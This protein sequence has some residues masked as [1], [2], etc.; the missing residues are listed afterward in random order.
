MLQSGAA[1]AQVLLSQLSTLNLGAISREIRGLSW[2]G[3]GGGGA[4]FQGLWQ[5]APVAVKFMVR[6]LGCSW[7]VVLGCS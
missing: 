5:G 2:I 4:V 3:Q 7:G 6:H 1:S